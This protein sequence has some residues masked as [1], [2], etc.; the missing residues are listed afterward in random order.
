MTVN[1]ALVGK[2]YPPTPPYTISREKI[3]EFADAIKD[4]NPAYRCV[5]AARALGHPDVVGP[6]T[7]PV[8]ITLGAEA[9]LFVD[10]ESGIDY[11]RVVHGE[12]RFVHERPIFAGD[13]LH[14]VL[15][16]DDIRTAGSNELIIVRNE[17]RSPDD[18]LVVTGHAV[19]VVRSADR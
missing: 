5:D 14:A 17:V 6:P 4:P 11:G 8:L 1:P 3:R 10:P 2:V 9:A 19:H 7:I 13:T 12:Q 18:A 16:I 15:H